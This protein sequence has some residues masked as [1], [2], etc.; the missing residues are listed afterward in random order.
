MASWNPEFGWKDAF[1]KMIE[2]EVRFKM[3]KIECIIRSEK[4]RELINALREVGVGGI[5]IVEV[6][7]FGKETTRP[8]PYLILPKVKIEIY[9]SDRQIEELI[10][11][12]VDVCHSGKLGDG[13]IIV[14]PMDDAIRIRT[15]ER[16]EKA[17]F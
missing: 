10:S 12:I 8:E 16:K 7:G 4:L 6:K 5:T 13:K 1:N 3:K 15:G 14:L 2:R 17:L 9:V 11:T